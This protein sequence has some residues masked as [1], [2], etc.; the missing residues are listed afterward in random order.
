MTH[1]ESQK[2]RRSQ[3]RQQLMQEALL[4]YGRLSRS[5]RPEVCIPRR[6]DDDPGPRG[7]RVILRDRECAEAYA[8][9]LAR[10]FPWQR[11]QRAYPCPRSRH[12]HYHLTSDAGYQA[13]GGAAG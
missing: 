1:T 4:R 12:G 13:T 2:R 5:G 9:E 8:A 7:P 10:I 11:P 6:A 3:V